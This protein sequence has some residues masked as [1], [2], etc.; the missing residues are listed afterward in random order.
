MGVLLR[1]SEREDTIRNGRS[2]LQHSPCATVVVLSVACNGISELLLLGSRVMWRERE[3]SIVETKGRKNIY[4]SILN[5]KTNFVFAS[6][7]RRLIVLYILYYII[8]YY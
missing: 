6:F 5:I 2:I 1:E 3:S 4:Y 7:C 8:L